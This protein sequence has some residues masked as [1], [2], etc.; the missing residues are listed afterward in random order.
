MSNEALQ[1]KNGAHGATNRGGRRSR[2]NKNE[3]FI[4]CL[5]AGNSE[6]GKL[7]FSKPNEEEEILIAALKGGV[8]YYRLQKF[9]ATVERTAEGLKIVGVPA[10]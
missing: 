10:E 6:G 7:Q 3:A 9:T 2:K 1:T 5:E 4:Y 8:P